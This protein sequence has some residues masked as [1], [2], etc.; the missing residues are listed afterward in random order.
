MTEPP[1]T[2]GPSIRRTIVTGLATTVIGLLLISSGSWLAAHE[3]RN[4]VILQTDLSELHVGRT[5]IW[6]VR[7]S[8]ISDYAFNIEIRPPSSKVARIE[9]SVDAPCSPTW[10]GALLKGKSIEI[11]YVLD[12]QNAQLSVAM[13]RTFVSA[14][15]EE[16]DPETGLPQT[17]PPIFREPGAA[18]FSNMTWTAACYVVPWLIVIAFYFVCTGLWKLFTRLRARHS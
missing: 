15:Y 9:C 6:H 7:L 4:E 1:A 12:D 5:S 16:R 8:N 3:V 2:S 11:L 17:N 10:K 18:P 14:S 13:L